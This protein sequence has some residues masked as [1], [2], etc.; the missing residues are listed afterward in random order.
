[1]RAMAIRIDPHAAIVQESLERGLSTDEAAEFRRLIQAVTASLELGPVRTM[2]D[3]SAAG[4][5]Q[6]D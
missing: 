3:E 4:G 2:H 5:E 6:A 1:G